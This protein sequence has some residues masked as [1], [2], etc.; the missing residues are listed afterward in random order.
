MPTA[1]HSSTLNSRLL[2]LNSTEQSENVYEKKGQAQKVAESCNAR[3]NADLRRHPRVR[4]FAL[5]RS[6]ASQ[7]CWQIGGVV[8][9]HTSTSPRNGNF[10]SSISIRL[11]DFLSQT[12]FL[13]LSLTSNASFFSE[14]GASA[15]W[16][17]SLPG[18]AQPGSWTHR[19]R[20]IAKTG[21]P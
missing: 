15:P 18:D 11:R 6:A 10:G 1:C 9:L 3:P 21:K 8:H 14:E 13:P 16:A 17:P 20:R 5:S 12:L 4:T 19:S 7:S 2:D